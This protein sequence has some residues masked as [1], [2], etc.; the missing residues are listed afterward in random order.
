[1]LLIGADFL[2]S[3]LSSEQFEELCLALGICLECGGSLVSVGGEVAC[4]KCGMVWCDENVLEAV[5]FPEG[6]GDGAKSH[7]EG[8]WQPGSSLCFLKGLGDPVLDNNGGKGLIKVLALAPAEGEDL[9]LRARRIKIMVQLEEPPQLRRILSRISQIIDK[10]G[11]RG[12]YEIAAYTGNLARKIVA[13]ALTAHVKVPTGWAD[14]IV[15]HALNKLKLNV[16]SQDQV[17]SV[18]NENLQFVEWFEDAIQKFKL[19]EIK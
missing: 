6:E 10:L 13:F 1:M 7:L 5:P 3:R 2:R 11:F 14:A 4:I 18:K 16:D 19:R 8:H 9:G 12:N 15:K 17:L